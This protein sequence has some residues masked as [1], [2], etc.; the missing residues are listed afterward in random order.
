MQHTGPAARGDR[1]V[2]LDLLLRTKR[3]TPVRPE[4][5]SPG[6]PG[7]RPSRR[8]PD[9]SAFA[10]HSLGMVWSFVYLAL[11]RLLELLVLC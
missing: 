6:V 11:G 7:L 9:P 8:N 1:P 10:A 5:A 4:H 2:E 3:D